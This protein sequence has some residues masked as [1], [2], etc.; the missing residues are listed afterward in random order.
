MQFNNQTTSSLFKKTMKSLPE[1]KQAVFA[2][3]VK[4]IGDKKIVSDST[5]FTITVDDLK[6]ALA[7]I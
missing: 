6:N 5:D 2:R 1:N 7:T 3:T 4:K